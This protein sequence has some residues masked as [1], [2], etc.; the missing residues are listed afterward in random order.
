MFSCAIVAAMPGHVS[1]VRLFFLLA[2]ASLQGALHAAL[3]A[4]LQGALHAALHAALQGALHAALHAA[5]QSALHAAL[6]A[7]LNAAL[8][9]VSCVLRPVLRVAVW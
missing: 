6:H 2:S 3:H 8:H 5:L 9:A 7:A 1:F 4:A